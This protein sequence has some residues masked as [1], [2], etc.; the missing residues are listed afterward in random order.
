MTTIPWDQTDAFEEKKACLDVD[1]C[2]RQPDARQG[3]EPVPRHAPAADR[4]AL[5]TDA[6]GDQ[7]LAVGV[8]VVEA[9]VEASAPPET[10]RYEPRP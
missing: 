9:Y 2:E 7:Q 3:A 5:P 8:D 6:C 1:A 10:N 4:Q